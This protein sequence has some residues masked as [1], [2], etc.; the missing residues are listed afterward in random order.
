[1]ASKKI[2]AVILFFAV[3]LT[4][5]AVIYFWFFNQPAKTTLFQP[6]P[7]RS[8]HLY[9]N[10]DVSI[11]K[12][13]LMVFY[14]VPSD[15]AGLIYGD[16]KN[17][18]VRALKKITAFHSLQFRGRSEINY[19]IYPKPV[20]L[21]NSASFYDSNNN[22]NARAL[23][24][25]AE[26]L[27]KREFISHASFSEKDYPVLGII[28]E[29]FGAIGGVIEESVLES[30]EEF[31]KLKNLPESV[32]FKVAIESADGFFLISKSY[33]SGKEHEFSGPSLLY[34]EFAHTLGIPDFYDFGTGLDFSEDIM[35][36]GR[37]RPLDNNYLDADILK[38]LGVFD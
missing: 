19:E 26:E 13:K 25:I 8:A 29:G 21:E 1:M 35:G 30:A 27:E 23:K 34:H 38:E 36:A 24:L 17:V 28:Y 20:I 22:G 33:L 37:N 32:V 7:A 4:A 10:P 3:S 11:E 15:K 14:T 31:A 6:Q 18:V 9:R 2:I 5:A 16:W 12:I